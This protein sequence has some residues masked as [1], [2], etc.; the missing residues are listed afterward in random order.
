MYTM[1]YTETPEHKAARL[2]LYAWEKT[3]PKHHDGLTLGPDG[4]GDPDG[5]LLLPIGIPDTGKTVQELFS[6]LYAAMDEE[7]FGD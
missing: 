4:Y 6:E 1:M 7:G 3:L 5:N 2:A